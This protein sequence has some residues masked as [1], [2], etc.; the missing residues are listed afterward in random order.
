[1]IIILNWLTISLKLQQ[2]QPN[3]NFSDL[4]SIKKTAGIQPLGAT[5]AMRPN[6]SASLVE[7]MSRILWTDRSGVL[8]FRTREAEATIMS[9]L[10]VTR[11]RGLALGSTC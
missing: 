5:S 10:I 4:L 6:S 2:W 7:H 11:H 3:A 1:M 9:V 8:K